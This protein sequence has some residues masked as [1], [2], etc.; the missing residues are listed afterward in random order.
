MKLIKELLKIYYASLS[1]SGCNRQPW[2][3]VV[4]QN[5]KDLK[6][7]VADLLA[8][9]VNKNE[10][11]LKEKGDLINAAR[12]IKEAPVFVLVFNKFTDIDDYYMLKSNLVS[13][14]SSIEHLLLR[15]TDLNIGSLWL[16]VVNHMEDELKELL[17]KPD[18]RIVAG[19]V[20]GYSNQE[21]K[22]RGRLSLDE[23]C[24]WR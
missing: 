5:D 2:R 6:N 14:G 4:L 21:P 15:A 9:C 24:D 18:M 22:D 12:I 10:F 1:P 7:K 16:G 3:F 23:I 19:I 11:T 13:I 20:L 8:N 17:N